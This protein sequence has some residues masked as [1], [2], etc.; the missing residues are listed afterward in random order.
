MDVP[1]ISSDLLYIIFKL[2]NF[3][4]YYFFYFNLLNFKILVVRTRFGSLAQGMIGSK[5]NKPNTMN[6]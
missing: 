2:V 1:L 3:F 4:Y 6:L 5:P